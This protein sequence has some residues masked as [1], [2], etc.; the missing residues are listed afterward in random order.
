V[1]SDLLYKVAY[2]EAVRALSEQQA[3]IDSFRTRGGMLLSA[4]AITT[5]FLGAQAL[6]RGHSSLFAW[7]AL[8]A[9]GG[10]A[11]LSLALLWP[12]V[13]QVTMDPLEVVAIHVKSE[14]P[15]AT[16]ALHRELIHNMH[17]GYLRNREGLDLLAVLF[18]IASGLSALEI[19]LWMVAI[20][21]TS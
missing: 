1:S 8:M 7:L 15:V 20:A 16:E 19:A 11:A 18:Q 5:S 2:D 14:H 10:V 6:Q 21:A 12:C 3:E 13:W 4:A 17:A 9:F